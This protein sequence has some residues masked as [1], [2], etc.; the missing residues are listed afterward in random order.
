MEGEAL[1]RFQRADSIFGAAL[2]R[3]PDERGGYVDAACGEDLELRA[4]VHRLLRAHTRSAEFFA[5]SAAEFAA[6]LI[7]P[8][9]LRAELGRPERVGPFRIMREIGHGGMGAVYLGE[10]DDG[11]FRQRVAIKLIRGGFGQDQ[12][13]R[14]FVQERQILASLEHP[15]I[16]RLLDGGVSPDGMP[17]FAMEY[18]EG[19]PI[20][21]FCARRQLPLEERLRLF[22]DV[23]DAVDHAHGQRVVHRDLKPSN[24]LV[25]PGG[26]VKLLDFGVAKLLEAGSGEIEAPATRTA[27]RA[28][29]PEYAAPEQVRGEPATTAAD[30]YA[31]G[32]LLY[33]LLV[34]ERPYRLRG[35]SAGEV[36][37]VVCETEPPLPS[38]AARRLRAAAGNAG[39]SA[40]EPGGGGS[41]GQD[42]RDER[43][44]RRLRGDLDTIVIK[45]LHKQ[46]ERRYA[47]AGALAD[48]LRRFA[49]GKPVLARP[50]SLAY[51][52]R[53]YIDRRRSRLGIAAA[54]VA[55]TLG[56]VALYTTRVAAER[57]GS[58]T[59]AA[60][61]D[62]ILVADFG[63]ALD[64]S[65]LVRAVAEAV[66][67]D[68]AQ[69]PAVRVLSPRQVAETL[70]HMGR[71][72]ELAVNDSL[73][74]ELAA[75]D[76]VK[77]IIT[78]EVQRLT[79]RY[80][81][82]ARLV[83]TQ[84]GELLAAARETA[85]S[86]QLMEAIGRLSRRLR[87]DL[88]ETLPSLRSSPPLSRVTTAS[89]PALRA[90]SE[91]MRHHERLGDRREALRLLEEAVAIDPGFASAYRMLGAI[92]RAN[93]EHAKG[94]AA[95]ERAFA[96]RDRLAVRE[97]YL[98]MGSHY[99]NVT[100]EYDRAIAAYRAQLDRE[101]TDRAA[102][103]NLSL[104]YREQRDFRNEELLL[105]QIIAIETAPPTVYLALSESLAHQ[106]RFA[107]AR[108]V[109]EEA[110]RLFPDHPIMPMSW[111]YVS[112]AQQDW[113]AAEQHIRRRLEQGRA[114]G[115]PD[116]V[117][118]A[119]QTLGQILLVTGRLREAERELRSAMALAESESSPRRA[120]F[121]AVQL[122]WLELR[123]RDRPERALAIVDSL[124]AVHP[125]D[126]LASGDRPYA[127]LTGFFAAVGAHPRAREVLNVA[128][129][130]SSA[131]VDLR[132]PTGEMMRGFDA[133][134]GGRHRQAVAAFLQAEAS[135]R[136]T[137]CALPALGEV[138]ERVGD[139]GNAVATYERYLHTPWK[140]RFEIDAPH[141]AWTMQRLAELYRQQGRAAEATAMLARLQR[142]W[143]DAD[144]EVKQL[145]G[146]APP[147]EVVSGV[148][149]PNWWSG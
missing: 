39:R 63:S 109:L 99:L 95:F 16:A 116:D 29:T 149:P 124:L 60:P 107:E 54:F 127:E 56:F 64:D 134:L 19:E 129:R 9:A 7:D 52:F 31:L 58:A 139:V 73:A 38:V 62:R 14:R 87:R 92:Y 10:R 18:I 147:G 131:R 125:L 98:T 23:C 108:A 141:L 110:D 137:I 79:G 24:I 65:V 136:C 47:S 17:Y 128:E 72:S 55:L 77:A 22:R 45:A 76:G 81:I 146:S 36:E 89:L 84:D 6:P 142:L 106:S 138:Y 75:R 15:N 27:L 122:G 86:T 4:A 66:R 68:L 8:A 85:D 114:R 28:L 53:K 70:Q 20:D 49:E 37:R 121:S 41:R 1:E 43:W 100:R 102:L 12:L 30:V 112:A 148:P 83:A 144:P 26:Q 50:D 140:W 91:A 101:P 40:A 119:H 46:A 35:R 11:Q 90:Y 118:D 96:H 5:H 67:I 93:A 88:G 126:R 48:D 132:G 61:P 78:G 3:A 145:P 71:P 130:D 21:R 94:A 69:F 25:T 135:D 2:D 113:A 74:L 111:A 33:E 133:M 42:I 57:S 104:V 13:V 97:R 117:M 59:L 103:N 143:R 32:V 123:Y 44:W 115:R 51:R 34:G 82:A 80:I 120:L 105:R